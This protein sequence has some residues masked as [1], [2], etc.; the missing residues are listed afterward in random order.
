MD[1][2]ESNVEQRL[3]LLPDSRLVLEESESIFNGLLEYIGDAEPTKAHFQCLAI[4]ALPLAHVA[5][6]V[7]VGK[8]VHL[9]FYETIAFASLA[10]T[11]LDV[12]R[13]PSRTVAADLCL[14]ELGEQLANRRE[15]SRV[16]GWIG[17][18]RA[19]DRALVDV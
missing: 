3:Q 16:S 11:A 1:V 12:E 13:K 5:R 10:A 4:V 17:P 15:Q 6:H 9:D 19:A 18:R 8:K 14:R 2:A 7:H